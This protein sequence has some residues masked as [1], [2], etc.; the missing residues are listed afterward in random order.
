[1]NLEGETWKW[2]EGDNNIKYRKFTAEWEDIMYVITHEVFM[3]IPNN[4]TV[5]QE[6]KTITREKNSEF[7]L[8]MLTKHDKLWTPRSYKCPQRSFAERVVGSF[9]QG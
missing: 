1:M 8:V 4:W 9:R 7:V 2:V 3:N 6:D 5:G